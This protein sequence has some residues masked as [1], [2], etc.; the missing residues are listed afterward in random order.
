M[1]RELLARLAPEVG[2]DLARAILDAPQ[3]TESEFLAQRERVAALRTRLEG[4]IDDEAVNLGV[5]ADFLIRRSVWIVGGDGWA[6]DIGYGG[7]DHVLAQDRDVNVLVLDTEVYSNT[8]GQASKATPLGASAKFAAAG[9]RVPRKDLAMQAIAYGYVYVAQVAMG[10]NAEQTLVALREAEAY[11]GPS[12]ILAYSHCIAHGFDLRYGMKQQA[13]ATASGYW[14]LF[15][16]DPS[17]RNSGANPFR[18]D[19]TRPRL[20]LE[21]FAYNELR[22]SVLTQGD[23]EA[24]AQMMRQAQAAVDERY[25][26][27]EDLAARD[28][29]R[30]LPNWETA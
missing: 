21:E 10:A 12:L 2:E 18:L 23:R 8:G 5:L 29:S 14:P 17:L 27:Y 20:K 22:Y 13:R 6:Y 3:V 25:R 1:A 26:T 7:L 15:R 24:A 19:S 4:R 30:F 9:K 16:Y 28:G 11:P